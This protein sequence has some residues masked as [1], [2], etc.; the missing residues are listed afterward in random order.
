MKYIK[1]A[2]LAVSML[3]ML[4]SVCYADVE[5]HINGTEI[6]FEEQEPVIVD[7]STLVPLR[8]IFE[9]LGAHVD[10]IKETKTVYATRRFSYVMMTIGA[11]TY[12]V[13]GE[14]KALSVVPCIYNERTMVPVR[15]VSESLG[16]DIEWDHE[17]RRVLIT[18]YDGEIAVKDRYI[19]YSDTT[20]N[21]TVLFTGRVAYPEL[22][23]DGDIVSAFNEYILGDAQEAMV[24]GRTDCYYPALDAY[25]NSL[26]GGYE[27]LPYMAEHSFDITY[28]KDKLI[29]ILCADS[30]FAGWTHPNYSM[31]SMTYNLE[32]G[33]EVSL[34]ELFDMCDDAI[35][36][37][38]FAEYSNMIEE[39]PESFYHDASDCLK[40]ALTELRWYL[41]GDGVHFF[42]NPYEIAPY[43]AGVIEAVL[44]INNN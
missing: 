31:Y 7:G 1:T 18:S 14:E 15:A 44:P 22:L 24:R 38:V 23:A 4:S 41:A 34:G 2:I 40:D 13:N 39:K 20:E 6:T 28:N 33:K 10:W 29:S 35:F 3:L 43:A 32:T 25:E 27:F 42:I 11:E 17:N 12:T 8:K 26:T 5:V 19:N 16:C 9:E 30:N 36:E 37:K 21:G